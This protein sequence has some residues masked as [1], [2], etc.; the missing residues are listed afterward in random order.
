[1]SKSVG[2]LSNKKIELRVGFMKNE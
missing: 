1:M 2:S